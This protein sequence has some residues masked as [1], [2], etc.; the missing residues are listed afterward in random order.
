MKKIFNWKIALLLI[1]LLAAFLRLWQLGNVPY[2][3]PDDEAAYVYN[4]YS[5]WHTGKDIL[6][7]FMPLSF[8]AHSSMSPIVVYLTAPFV[9]ILDISPFSGRL[10][11]A[12]LAIGSVILLFFISDVIFKNKKV[13]V[14][15]ALVFAISPWALQ[16]ARG[17]VPD[18]N[19][20][21]FFLLLGIYVFIKNVYTKNFL[22]SLIPFAVAFYSYHATKVFF[23]FL[24]VAL[25]FVFRRELLN[26]KKQG[27]IFVAACILILLSFLIVI[28]TQA[29]TRQGDVS[30]L[31]DPKASIAV[32]SERT[33]SLAPQFLRPVFSN[34][35]LYFLRTMRESYFKVFSTEYLFLSGETGN[36]SQIVNIFFRG[37][38]YIIE[39]PLLLI[40]IYFLLRS[41][42]RL[43]RNF[44]FAW[45]LI[46]PLPSTFTVDKNFVDR[47]VMLLPALMLLVSYGLY[48]L[49]V[50]I[51]SYKKIYKYFILAGLILAYMC[52]F[53]SYF[54]Q[55]YFRWPLYGAEG[56][57]TSYRD[58]TDYVNVK[59]SEYKNIYISSS[60]QTYLIKY[61]IYNKIDPRL[62]Q[63]LWNEDPIKIENITMFPGCLNSTAGDVKEFLPQNTLYVSSFNDCHYKLSTPS[64]KIVDRGEPLHTIWD[65]YK[66]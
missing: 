55:Y 3:V 56:W 8:N 21:L 34:K 23:V 33:Y 14:L 62:V 7:N 30:L 60:G 41:K 44:L 29:V 32:N 13:A 46:S 42:D 5:I 27:G 25:I 24:I 40:G 28:K 20:S 47:D 48:F 10:A 2:G 61:A 45:I 43:F 35:P 36:S 4:A 57:G 1:I 54:Y 16:I 18:V 11:S 50:K 37:E 39:L 66:N 51:F 31:N 15:S 63:K 26:K 59:K 12:L 6:G 52:L 22:W 58:L 49:L 38:L 19:F 9:G 53:S 65:I 17:A 64:G